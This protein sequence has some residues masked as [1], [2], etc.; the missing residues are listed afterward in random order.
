MTGGSALLECLSWAPDGPVRVLE[1]GRSAIRF[2]PLLR[3]ARQV[4]WAGSCLIEHRDEP[5]SAVDRDWPGLPGL[6]ALKADI[7]PASLDLVV[8]LDVLREVVDP[9]AEVRA[10]SQLLTP[11]GRLIISVPNLRYWRALAR[12]GFRGREPGATEPSIRRASPVFVLR[13]AQELI[14][15]AELDLLATIPT[16]SRS[17]FHEL[18]VRE[19]VI[20]AGKP[21]EGDIRIGKA[22]ASEGGAG[23]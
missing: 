9:P 8:C 16:K 6:A 11:G 20:V 7:L 19:W 15:S 3:K 5:P 12:L 1:V 10:L 23:G 13:S 17:T 18:I 22:A 4:K 2:V 21:A 14:S